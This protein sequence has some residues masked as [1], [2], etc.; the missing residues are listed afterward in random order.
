MSSK[1]MRLSFVAPSIIDG[2]ITA[3]LDKREIERMNKQWENALVM[4]VV[5]QNPTITA[6]NAYVKA[7]WG[8]S[9]TPSALFKHE[10]GFFVI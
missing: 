4:D 2:S 5:G 3:K 10:E 1:G 7:Q 9:C 6:M 8:V